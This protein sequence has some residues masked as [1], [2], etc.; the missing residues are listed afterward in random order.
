MSRQM[1]IDDAQQTATRALTTNVLSLPLAHIVF[2]VANNEDWIDSLVFMVSDSGPPLEQLDLSGIAF[3]MHLRRRPE[4]NEVVLEASTLDRTL[5]IGSPPDLGY[6][7]VYVP[8]ETMRQLWPGVYVGDIV[9]S[10][11]SFQR[12]ALTVEVT[13]IEGV[14][15]Q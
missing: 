1:Q 11:A 10:D 4:L 9:A 2:A 7:I 12:V 3:R 6:L 5:Y 13:V 15:R 14:T 8:E